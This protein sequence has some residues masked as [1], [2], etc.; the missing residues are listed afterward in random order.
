MLTYA[1]STIPYGRPSQNSR[2]TFERSELASGSE[3]PRP[4]TSTAVS[5]FSSSGT[6]ELTR[7]SI[8]SNN[9]GRIPSARPYWKSISG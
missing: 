7:S 2:A 5:P 9:S 3:E 6:T 8:S 1:P 4:T